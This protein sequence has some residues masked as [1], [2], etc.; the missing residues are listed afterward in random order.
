MGLLTRRYALMLLFTWI[1]FRAGYTFLGMVQIVA[2]PS[3]QMM[4]REHA[5]VRLGLD[6]NRHEACLLRIPNCKGHAQT[7]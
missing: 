3:L 2:R 7:I 5:H 4:W 6:R 1:Y